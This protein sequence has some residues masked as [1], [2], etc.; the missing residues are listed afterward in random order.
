M[1]RYGLLLCVACW[2]A[3]AGAT[4]TAGDLAK[5]EVAAYFPP[6][7]QVGERLAQLPAWPIT[8]ELR[9]DDGPIGYAFESI[10]LAPIPGFEGTPVGLLPQ[11][12]R[13]AAVIEKNCI[14]CKLC[15]QVCIKDAVVVPR[16][17]QFEDIG[18]SF[19]SYLTD[20]H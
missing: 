2:L 15:E 5:E 19:M 20:E 9:P 4:A 8:S 13:I 16:A 1:I 18:M 6:P 14:S 12:N 11:N 17:H 10:D 7:L 3:L